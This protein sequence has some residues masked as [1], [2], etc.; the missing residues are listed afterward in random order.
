MV[1]GQLSQQCY[2]AMSSV[3]CAKTREQ[4]APLSLVEPGRAEFRVRG[5]SGKV[6][7]GLKDSRRYDPRLLAA[8]RPFAWHCCHWRLKACGWCPSRFD[9]E[10]WLE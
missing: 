3:F 10:S 6:V 1:M 8:V 5:G 4:S 2:T 9:N 7:G